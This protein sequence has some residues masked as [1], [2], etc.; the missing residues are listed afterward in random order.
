MTIEG[1]HKKEILETDF[2]RFALERLKKVKISVPVINQLNNLIQTQH[3]SD[4]DHKFML[5]SKNAS[6]FHYAYRENIGM[7][8]KLKFNRKNQYHKFYLLSPN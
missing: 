8:L 5:K 2:F 1:D 3:K 4:T 7:S 6:L